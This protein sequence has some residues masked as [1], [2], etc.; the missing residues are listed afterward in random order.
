[1]KNTDIINKTFFK[2]LPV[3][4]IMVAVGSI[5]SIIDGVV[6]TNMLNPLALSACGLFY[7][8]IKLMD[9]VN[10]TLLGGSQILCGQFIGKNQIKRAQSVFSLDM[11][12]IVLFGAILSILCFVFCQPIAG[13]MVE[14]IK[15]LEGLCDY[16]RGYAPGIIP[17][18]LVS[19]LTAFLQIENQEKRTYIGM[20]MMI[21]TNII[22]DVLF[23]GVFHMG[24]FG[25]GL[26]TALSN[27]IYVFVLASFYMMG[28]AGVGFSF[29][30]IEIKD[31]FS[32]IKIGLPGAAMQFAQMIRGIVLNMLMLKFVGEFG[33]VAFSAV[34][35]FGCL[36]YA[37]T[38]GVAN[39][40]RV[41]C[42]VYA[43]EEDRR[44]LKTVMEIS[45]KKGVAMV[46]VVMLVLIAGSRIFTNM[47][48]SMAAGEV[49]EITKMGFL[50]F[51]LTMPLSCICCIYIN[52]YQCRNEL[53]IANVLSIVDGMVGVVLFSVIL[54][55]L[56]SMNGI[57]IS[58]ILNGVLCVITILFY[59]IIKQKKFPRSIEDTL[60][61]PAA[62]GVME[63]N[64][65]DVSI[66]NMDETMQLSEQVMDFCKKHQIDDM[67][68]MYAGLSIE[69]MVGNI[70][71]HGFLDGKKH[72]IDVRVIYRTEENLLIRIKDDCKFF[73]P[74]A[75]QR[76]MNPNDL[77]KNIGIRMIMQLARNVD[78][79]N[80]YGLNVLTIEI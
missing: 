23:V 40:T 51:P 22:S 33:V 14:D 30:T 9:T 70:V 3:Q 5:N 41:L 48:Y 74:K 49:Y 69:E 68:S 7:P 77:S 78:Y 15:V 17:Y 76:I 47:F 80:S 38:A 26:A 25:L 24:L 32:T 79:I 13:L 16:M 20:V 34:N 52:Y 8:I 66:H 27:Y 31:F 19:Q 10:V 58:H 57:W 43:G 67:R 11:I 29:S 64:C 18:L 4:I 35:S 72:T 60:L 37:T 56:I 44:A 73:N 61:L 42:S 39:A 63:E 6:A 1:M 62:Y 53:K 50:M 55:P 36:F 21:I 28:K 71:T 12:S 2:L 75:I 54:A 46:T 45:L 59:T 65:I